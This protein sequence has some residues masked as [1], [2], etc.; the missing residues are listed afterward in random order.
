MEQHSRSPVADKHCDLKDSTKDR[1]RQLLDLD[2]SIR[3]HEDLR[4]N[5][6][7]EFK[8]CEIEFE[9]CGPRNLTFMCVHNFCHCN[10]SMHALNTYRKKESPQ[11]WD[12]L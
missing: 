4:T 11:V 5:I 7:I 3:T 1:R 9:V 6:Q 12:K 8:L 2:V 10:R